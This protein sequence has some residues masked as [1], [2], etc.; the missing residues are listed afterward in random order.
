MVDFLPY[1]LQINH[2]FFQKL[3]VDGGTTHEEEVGP[4][5]YIEPDLEDV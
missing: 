1:I 2:D 5:S 3:S 4:L